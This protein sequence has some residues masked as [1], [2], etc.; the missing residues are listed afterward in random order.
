MLE[1]V[2]MDEA[3]A[4]PAAGEVLPTSMADPRWPA[5][6]GWVKMEQAIEDVEIHYV[7]NTR[8]CEVDDFKFKDRE[9][10]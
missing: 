9:D 5:H 6:E 2:A 8:T 4:D 10:E 3:M 7:F 1:E